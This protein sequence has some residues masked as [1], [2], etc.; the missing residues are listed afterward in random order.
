M[1]GFVD[2]GDV[3]AK[4]AVRHD[5]TCEYVV[6]RDQDVTAFL[7]LKDLCAVVRSTPFQ[8]LG[9]DAMPDLPVELGERGVRGGRDLLAR[10]LD[11]RTEVTDERRHVNVAQSNATRRFWQQC[12][13]FLRRFLLGRRHDFFRAR[14]AEFGAAMVRTSFIR[15]PT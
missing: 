1:T 8:H 3:F 13:Y 4:I 6:Y 7:D 2:R 10:V 12:C 15:I 11:H 5:Y 9:P 14:C